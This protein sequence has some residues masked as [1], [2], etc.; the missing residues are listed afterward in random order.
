[1]RYAYD[2]AGNVI[3]SVDGN[4][5]E[6]HY[7]YNEINKLSQI[8]WQ[9]E[10][11][12]EYLYDISGN[13]AKQKLRDGKTI[14]YT[15]NMYQSLT[16]R[17]SDSGA[18]EE[19]YQYD[20]VGRLKSA[21]A[22]GMR[23]DYS[24]YGDGSLKEKAASGRTLIAYEYDLNGN[25]AK[26]TDISGKTVSYEYD[27]YNRIN[28]VYDNTRLMAEYDYT[29]FGA[30]KRTVIP[31]IFESS[32]A[33]DADANLTSYQAKT[34]DYL[35]ADSQYQYDGN[36][37]LTTKTGLYGEYT[38]GYDSLNRLTSECFEKSQTANAIT[39]ESYRTGYTYDYAGNRLSMEKNGILTEYT[40]DSCNRL[41]SEKT[42]EMT[43]NFTYDVCGNLSHDGTMT[44]TYDELNRL[45][46]ITT[47][48]GH[49]QKHRYDAKGLRHELEEDGKLVQFLYNH[50]Q[51]VI[52]EESK[53]EGLKRYIRGLGLIS[54]DCEQSKTYYH[55]VSDN[56]GSITHVLNE[57]AEKEMSISMMHSVIR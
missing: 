47:Q 17:R 26:Q 27:D 51:E 11:T 19:S 46:E 13:L 22:G 1:M 41:I 29:L 3:L 50:K 16:S 37:N 49:V 36:G 45:A 8:T 23:Y 57:N 34:A 21:I 2:Y 10:T 52:A 18:I 25:I 32:Y 43:R 30:K 31:G 56:V 40:Y 5:N 42:G 53:K 33:Y 44:Y 35:L 12:E 15:Y 48:D 14:T 24:Y 6:V 7:S 39:T 38:Y 28:K 9:D 54:S 20:E 55:Y 4:G